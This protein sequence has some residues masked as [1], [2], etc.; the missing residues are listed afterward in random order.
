MDPD[1]SENV[2]NQIVSTLPFL[3][4]VPNHPITFVA[5]A[6]TVTLNNTSS[7]DEETDN[8]TEVLASSSAIGRNRSKF[9][10]RQEPN[11]KNLTFDELKKEMKQQLL[12]S[13]EQDYCVWL[14]SSLPGSGKSTILLEIAS[15]LNREQAGKKIINI[16]LQQHY[17]YFYRERDTSTNIVNLLYQSNEMSHNDAKKLAQERKSIV[18]LD[19]FDEI[20]PRFRENVMTIIKDA[21]EKK[22]PLVI[23]TR[24]EEEET[25]LK[26]L[27]LLSTR[28]IV[29]KPLERNEQLKLLMNLGKNKEDC[30]KLFKLFETCGATDILR[31]PFHLTLISDMELESVQGIFGIYE[32]V[33]KKKVTDA[34]QTSK[35]SRTP[36]DFVVDKRIQLLQEISLRFLLNDGSI[37]FPTEIDLINNTG[38]ASMEEGKIRFVHQTFAEFLVA[39]RFIQEIEFESAS[40]IP[41]FKNANLRQCRVFINSYISQNTTFSDNLSIFFDQSQNV[42]I[43]SILREQ[44]DHILHELKPNLKNLLNSGDIKKRDTNGNTLLLLAARFSSKEICKIFVENG[45]DLSAE[46]NDGDDAFHLACFEEKLENAKYLLGLNGFSVEKKGRYGRTA[47]HW[48][49]CKGHVAVAEFL[50]SIGVNVTARD[51]NNDTP[52]TLAAQLSSEEM[53]RFLVENG[54]DLS[55]VNK[56]GNDALHFACI[57]GKLENVKY[58]LGLNGFSVEKKGWNGRSA[59]HRAAEKGHVAV[60]KFLLS[61]G[62]NVNARDDEKSTPLN[63]AAQYSSEEMCQFLVANGADMSAVDKYG[64]TTLCIWPASM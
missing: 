5:P 24:P 38:V 35:E 37:P 13:G 62:A 20:C 50:L 15:C 56:F 58:L 27:D 57:R 26:S 60:A 22:I 25:L 40:S 36:K 46:D 6:V 33:I 18:F 3:V 10:E 12:S 14:F 11:E 48:A 64:Q 7:I 63:L 17:G 53:C 52:L 28:K 9:S 34:L 44:L 39:Q 32:V 47:L 43:H 31:N 4:D 61:R 1:N 59:L 49:A 16:Q 23:A 51:D 21:T 2:T 41:I 19:G 42:D 55:A 29:I 8:H 45:A 54:A 30:E